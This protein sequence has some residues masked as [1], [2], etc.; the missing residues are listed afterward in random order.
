MQCR[1][2]HARNQA[3]V[4]VRT[5]RQVLGGVPPSKEAI[6]LAIAQFEAKM[7]VLLRCQV[8]DSAPR[9]ARVWDPMCKRVLAGILRPANSCK[10]C[11]LQLEME[12]AARMRVEKRGRPSKARTDF[13]A[14]APMQVPLDMRISGDRQM[15]TVSETLAPTT[16]A[17]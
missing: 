16:A 5:Q 10:L 11:W 15:V 3:H 13:E 17:C 9:H 1:I 14:S 8:C 2:Q 7:Q 6:T 4:F 12:E